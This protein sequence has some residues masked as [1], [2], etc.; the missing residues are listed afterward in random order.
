[1]GGARQVARDNLEVNPI[2]TKPETASHMAEQF[3]WVPLPCYSLPQE[4]VPNKV[5]CFVGTYVSSVHFQVLEKSPS[6]N[7]FWLQLPVL[8][9]PSWTRR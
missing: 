5:S 3:S 4:P 1:M 7:R 6:C 8:K 2:P 9:R